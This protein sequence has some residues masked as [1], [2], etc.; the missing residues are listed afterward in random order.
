MPV[1]V[2]KGVK[3]EVYVEQVSLAVHLENPENDMNLEQGQLVVEL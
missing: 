3:L 2:L 1:K